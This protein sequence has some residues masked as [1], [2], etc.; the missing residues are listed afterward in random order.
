MAIALQEQQF[1]V[2]E[3]IRGVAKDVPTVKLST[4]FAPESS[5]TF[6]Q[7]GKVRCMP[8]AAAT[9][10]DGSDDAVQTT[11]GNPI[12]HFWRHIAA[13][14]T[15]YVFVYTKAHVYIWNDTTKVY[16][17][18]FTCDSDCTTWSVVSIDGRV[19]STNNVDK[20]QVW[21]ESTPGT[22]FA[23]LGTASGLDL[24][25]GS[26]ITKARY[27]AVCENYLWVLGPTEA[28]TD[29]P[30]RG[31]WSSYGNV[32]NFDVTATGDTSYKDFL[33]GSDIIKGAGNYTYGGA[34]V[35]VIFKEHS[36][37]LAWLVES[38]DVWNMVAAEGA[39]GLLATHSVVNDKEGNVYYAASDYTI[40]KLHHGPISKPRINK[41]I[42]GISITHQANIVAAYIDQYNHLWW[43][44][45]STS[46]ST[47]NDKVIA[48]N[49]DY[50]GVW[51]EYPFAIRAFGHWSQQTSYTIDGLDAIAD[52]IDGLDA[53]MS[54][55]DWVSSLVGYPL[56][57]GSDYSGYAYNLHQS[58]QDMGSDLTREL[59]L[60][61][62]MTRGISLQQFKRC[63]RVD[64]WTESRATAQTISVHVKKDNEASWTSIGSID[65]QG[66]ATIVNN[67][68]VPNPDMRARHFLF[69]FSST[70]LFDWIGAL[71]DYSLDG[72]L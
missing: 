2:M 60:S 27:L 67:N 63:Y 19:I 66:T 72:F 10:L 11:D 44:I 23:P 34:D 8:G 12:I 53:A 14:G 1:G 26:Y 43:S 69:K 32:T 45:P 28:G 49:L 68:V 38:D 46:G 55:I 9:F 6:L 65:I 29:Y 35:L 41:T 62:Q 40:R 15:E 70:A 58:T 52:T 57:L 25:A 54:Q 13:S 17:T 50:P 61:V 47:G 59:V 33:Q 4:A 7:D 56:E 36:T 3:D 16:T 64:V 20:V 5:G 18:M 51:H 39:V 30:R 71:F 31:R 24:G 21:L 48:Y 22:V 37:H 42:K